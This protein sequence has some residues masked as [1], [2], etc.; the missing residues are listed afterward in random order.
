METVMKLPA[1][2]MDDAIERLSHGDANAS[3]LTNR[4]RHCAFKRICKKK[5]SKV[6]SNQMKYTGHESFD[7]LNSQFNE[8]RLFNKVSLKQQKQERYYTL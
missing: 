7:C 4:K 8:H 1:Q 6:S 3:I 5:K 2:V